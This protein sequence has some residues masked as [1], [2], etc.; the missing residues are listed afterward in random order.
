MRN[1]NYLSGYGQEIVEYDDDD[2]DEEDVEDILDALSGEDDWDELG[3]VPSPPG[4]TKAFVRPIRGRQFRKYPLGLGVT[5]IAA[6]TT[7]V[8]NV[9]P[10][11]PFKLQRISC[12]SVAA[13]GLV[14]DNIQIGTV[15]QFVAAGAVPVEIFAPDATGVELKG[16]TAVPGV[17]IQITVTNPTAGA[18][19]F[20]GALLGLVAQ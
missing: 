17:A 5:A 13:A 7:A 3:Q 2:Y 12:E 11:L 6:G 15:S 9:N 10:Q 1:R 20:T 19:N 4:R 14:I 18:L 8:I 16:D